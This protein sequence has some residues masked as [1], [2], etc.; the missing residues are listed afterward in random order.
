MCFNWI[1]NQNRTGVMMSKR[2]NHRP[3]A[4]PAGMTRRELLPS[5]GCGVLL[6]GGSVCARAAAHPSSVAE[7]VNG[8]V[9]GVT[10]RGVHIFRGVPYGGPTEGAGRFMPPSKPAKWAGVRDATVTGPRCIQ[11]E[12]NIFLHP[13][14]GEYFGG[15]RADRVELARQNT[16]LGEG[17]LKIKSFHT[18]DLP[19][20]MRLVLFPESEQ[21]SRQL[22][23]AWAAFARTGSPSQKGLEWPAYTLAERATMIFDGPKSGVVNDPDRDE[24]LLVRDR[25]SAGPL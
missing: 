20:T 12:G 11:G 1:E 9:R 15:G 22:S 16:P 19:L 3:A 13:I 23:G 18:C 6:A 5:I 25:P 14:I 2:T 8:R 4:L 24:R 10:V 21:L 17:T 7:T